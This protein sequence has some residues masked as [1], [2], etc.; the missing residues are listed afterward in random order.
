VSDTEWEFLPTA[1]NTV[2][3]K[4]MIK[5]KIAAPIIVG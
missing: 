1:I 5:R 2:E 4:A 3:Q